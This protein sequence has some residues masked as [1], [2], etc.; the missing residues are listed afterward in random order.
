MKQPE[1]GKKISELRKA[2]GLTQE[3]L[4]EKCNLNVRT[5][6]RIEAGEVTPRSYTVKALFDAL[7]VEENGWIEQNAKDQSGLNRKLLIASFIAG[8]VYFILGFLEFPMD[9]KMISGSGDPA[10]WN[11]FYM[12]IKLLVLFTFTLFMVG[13]LELSKQE[14]DSL[15]R[16]VTW[17]FLG[18]NAFW[19][20]IDI[21]LSFSDSYSQILYSVTKL[22]TVGLLY[23]IFGLGLYRVESPRKIYIRILG[24]LGILTGILLLTY[25]GAVGAIFT[26]AIFEIGLLFYL[27][28]YLK[29][30]GEL[31]LPTIPRME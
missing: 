5:I 29:K 25:V 26:M 16:I 27:M 24:S 15:F 21:A 11:S 12:V 17:V 9:L 18:G 10:N 22:G 28:T 30:S 14:N 20:M 4:V 19:M 1:L 3:E 31:L 2:K 23:A 8:I 13:F 7:G 6:Q